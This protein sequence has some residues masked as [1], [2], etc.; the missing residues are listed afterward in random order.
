MLGKLLDIIFFF[1]KKFNA[2]NLVF[3]GN[4]HT[5]GFV[6][7]LMFFNL[8]KKNER[9]LVKYLFSDLDTIEAGG[10]IGLVSMFLKR[11]IGNKKLIILEPNK[12]NHKTILKNFKSNSLAINPKNILEYGIRDYDQKNAKFNLYKSNFANSFSDNSI[13]KDSFAKKKASIKINTISIPSL[14]K[15]FKIKKFQLV[16]DIEGGEYNL[17]K[18][19]NNWMR[20]CKAV[21]L[22]N[23]LDENKT[24]EMFSILKGNKFIYKKNQVI[25]FYLLKNKYCAR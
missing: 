1:L 12:F 3:C 21:L 23:H 24:K 5:D 25:V 8:Y 13:Y 7:F 19:N 10:G 15:N 16:I 9:K 17:I 4:K 20:H 22:E 2:D 6:K 14:M 11:K 18:N